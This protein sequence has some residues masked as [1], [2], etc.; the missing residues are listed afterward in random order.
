[1]E[2]VER[3]ARVVSTWVF[4]VSCVLAMFGLI[5]SVLFLI[6]NIRYRSVRYVSKINQFYETISQIQSRFK[7]TSLLYK[8]ISPGFATSIARGGAT[9]RFYLID[10]ALW[11]ECILIT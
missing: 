3:D 2:D 5:P 6:F 8:K 4:V 1:M 7:K 11:W 10:V 9:I